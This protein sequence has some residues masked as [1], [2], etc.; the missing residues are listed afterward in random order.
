M[1]SAKMSA[2]DGRHS[3]SGV[4]TSLVSNRSLAELASTRCGACPDL[5]KTL[6]EARLAFGSSLPTGFVF[7]TE[8]G[9]PQSYASARRAFDNAV[10]KA[11]LG[12][13][14]TRLTLHAL[15]HTFASALIAAG[16]DVVRVSTVLGHAK[17]STTLDTYAAQF[18]ARGAHDM[19]DVIGAA[20]GGL[21]G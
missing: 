1:T 20:L 12:D 3:I 19:G 4:T 18:N 16:V 11:K 6:L 10:D 14:E 13:G 8:T 15:R 21:G 17:I 2:W 5:R 9:R 7:A